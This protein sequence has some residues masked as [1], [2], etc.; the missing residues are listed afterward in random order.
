MDYLI[1]AQ[2]R[3]MAINGISSEMN[4]NKRTMKVNRMSNQK[5]PFAY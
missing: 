2:Y 4:V 1:D 3:F 5:K